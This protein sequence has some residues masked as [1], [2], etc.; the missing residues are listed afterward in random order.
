[1]PPLR[2]YARIEALE[3]WIGQRYG[4]SLEADAVHEILTRVVDETHAVCDLVQSE[5]IA[6]A[7]APAGQSQSQSQGGQK[8]SQSQSSSNG[9]A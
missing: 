4:G 2:A 1:T 6:A 9:G 3:D 5:L 7:P 8:Q